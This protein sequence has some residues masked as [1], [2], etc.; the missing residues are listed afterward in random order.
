MKRRKFVQASLLGTP[1]ATTFS[2]QRIED[3][4]SKGFKIESGEGR[5]HG[6]IQLKGVNVNILDVKIS[7]KDTNGDLAVFEQTSLSPKRGTPLHIHP[8]QDEIFHIQDGEY[9]F[10]VGQDQHQLQAGD[11]IFCPEKYYP[12]P[13]LKLA[14][15]DA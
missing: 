14:R 11:S 7:G 15:K 12:R 9:R 4:D 10:V 3:R 2:L 1:F 13:G 5:Y 8:N 6:H